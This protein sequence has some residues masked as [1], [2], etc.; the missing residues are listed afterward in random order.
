MIYFKTLFTLIIYFHPNPIYIYYIFLICLAYNY[1]KKLYFLTYL[2][3]DDAFFLYFVLLLN[4][5]MYIFLL[6]LNIK[7]M[8]VMMILFIIK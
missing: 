5:W 3:N 2:I 6:S 1:T 7:L 4:M 8:K